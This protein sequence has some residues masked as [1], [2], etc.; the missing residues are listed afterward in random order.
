MYSAYIA[1]NIAICSLASLTRLSLRY[2]AFSVSLFFSASAAGRLAL[3]YAVASFL[4]VSIPCLAV[5]TDLNASRT[6][7]V[8]GSLSCTETA[9]SVS[10]MS[11]FSSSAAVSSL[12][13]I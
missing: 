2:S 4:A 1:S 12:T 11:Y 7:S 6:A 3:A 9:S 13:L 10:P 5:S 8:G